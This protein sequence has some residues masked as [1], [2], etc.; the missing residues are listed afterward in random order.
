M[1][2]ESKDHNLVENHGTKQNLGIPAKHLAVY[3][4]F[5]QENKC[6]KLTLSAQ[7]QYQSNEPNIT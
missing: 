4:I 6:R 7:K 1:T 3:Q 2:W 5:D